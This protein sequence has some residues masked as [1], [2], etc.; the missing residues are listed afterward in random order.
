MPKLVLFVKWLS[1]TKI[2]L[3]AIFMKLLA[4]IWV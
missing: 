2:E 4:I 1:A 3:T